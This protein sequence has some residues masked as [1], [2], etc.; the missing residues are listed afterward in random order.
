[1]HQAVPSKYLATEP[2]TGWTVP[3]AM[4]VDAEGRAWFDPQAPMHPARFGTAD[5]WVTRGQLGYVVDASHTEYRW[6][7]GAKVPGRFVAVE[8]V[9]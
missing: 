9:R 2:T 8:Q 5:L 3:W 6:T 1:M 7:A 4:V